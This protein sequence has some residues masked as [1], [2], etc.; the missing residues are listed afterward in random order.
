MDSKTILMMTPCVLTVTQNRATRL[1]TIVSGFKTNWRCGFVSLLILALACCA[2]S[3]SAAVNVLTFH[4]D[5]ARTGQNTN[6]TIL[7]PAVVS[8]ANFGKIFSHDVDGLV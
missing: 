5:N 1:R 3:S 2:N 4:N 7:T 8:S 6:E